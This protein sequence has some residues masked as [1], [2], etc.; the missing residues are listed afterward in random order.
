MFNVN[1]NMLLVSREVLFDV[2]KHKHAITL[3]EE[4]K[5]LSAFKTICDKANLEYKTAM[6]KIPNS[7]NEAM[8]LY[9]NKMHIFMRDN[10]DSIRYVGQGS[11]RIVFAMADGTAIKIAKTVAGIGQNWQEAKTCMDPKM[12]YQIFPDFYG[13]DKQTWLALNCE[14]CARALTSDFKEVFQAQPSVITELVEFIYQTLG[15]SSLTLDEKL[16]KVLQ[17]YESTNYQNIVKASLLKKIIS[18]QTE[19]FK[20]LKSLFKFYM[21]HTLDEL[22]VG[23]VDEVEN[24]GITYRNGQKVL[25]IIDAGFS[26]KIYNAFYAR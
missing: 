25:V 20:A 2:M 9:S 14:L 18:P 12:K 15:Q 3:S 5:N 19:A 11:S 21:E 26:E 22:L 16:D 10:K 17:H 23:D 13:A 6:L 4:E 1:N 8:D 7:K 24:W